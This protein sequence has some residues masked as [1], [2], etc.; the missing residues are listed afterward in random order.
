MSYPLQIADSF[1]TSN[2]QDMIIIA[3]ASWS[4][5]QMF[6]DVSVNSSGSMGHHIILRHLSE[7][8]WRKSMSPNQWETCSATFAFYLYSP[9]THNFIDCIFCHP[10]VSGPLATWSQSHLTTHSIPKE[11]FLH[12]ARNPCAGFCSIHLSLLFVCCISMRELCRCEGESLPILAML[13]VVCFCATAIES[14]A[15]K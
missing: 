13:S 11:C 14:R 5:C 9:W 3:F 12:R 15:P 8:G 6:S 2:R 4:T 1:V 7:Q 10:S